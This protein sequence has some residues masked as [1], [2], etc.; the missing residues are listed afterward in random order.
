M[1]GQQMAKTNQTVEMG[2]N[3]QVKAAM[4]TKGFPSILPNSQQQIR[5]ASSVS[6]QT[7]QTQTQLHQANMQAK[8]N[9]ATVRSKNMYKA[10]NMAPKSDA[11]NQT[12]N[13]N[14]PSNQQLLQP[15]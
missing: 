15:K 2:N 4:P 6:T 12:K 14:Q 9:R 8:G 7:G 5:P 1:Q 10:P 11:A 13:A 3:V